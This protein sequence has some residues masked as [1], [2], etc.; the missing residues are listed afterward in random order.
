M[1]IINFG[2]LNIDRVYQVEHLVRPGETITSQQYQE[3]C[4]GKGLNQ[5]IAL[6]R[7]GIEVCHAGK[8]GV[9]GSLLVKFL[10]DNGV[11]VSLV[12]KGNNLTGHAIIQVDANGENSIVLYAGENRALTIEEVSSVIDQAEAG[13]FLLLQN[14]INFI[15]EIVKQASSKGLSIVFN[16]APMT[17]EILS[18]PLEQVG[19]LM[20]NEVEGKAIAGK[21]EPSQ[22]MDEILDRYPTLSLVLTL[23]GNG[24]YFSDAN[25][26]YFVPAEEVDPIDTTAAGDTFIGYF[27]AEIVKGSSVQESLITANKAAALCV[28]RLGAADSIPNRSE[29]R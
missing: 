17:P 24:V 10:A 16:P 27:I 1:K 7:A 29:L 23:G 5:S 4:G 15:E 28:T 26:R 6:A 11:N 13:D 2:S 25:N 9:D 22:I 14:E 21:S 12:F 8:I 19:W 18:L 20:V 3:F